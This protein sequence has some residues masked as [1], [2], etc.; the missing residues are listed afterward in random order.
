[1]VAACAESWSLEL[2]APFEPAHISLVVPARL[3]D[4]SEA[5]LKINFPEAESE[6]EPDALAWWSGA[7]AV[8]LLA[9]DDERRALLLEPC[10]PGTALWEVEDGEAT[11][12]AAAVLGRLW[13]KPAPGAPFRR[14]EPEALRWA[15]ELPAQWEAAGRP[16]ERTLVDEAV[17]FMQEAANDPGKPV[18]LHQDLHG[19]NILRSGRDEW[20]AID[21]KPLV[22]EREFDTASLLRDRRWELASEPRAGRIVARRLD[23]L[24]DVLGLDRERMRGWGIAHALAWAYEGATF[25]PEH[26]VAARA[27]ASV[28]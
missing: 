13:Q 3:R 28:R 1:M 5:V 27:I 22:G 12:I 19:G 11:G 18:L 10:D 20:L 16:F 21:P 15:D 4:G 23:Q 2:D 26:V 6:H 9:R 7:G 25:L 17:V 8:R 24:A 14:L